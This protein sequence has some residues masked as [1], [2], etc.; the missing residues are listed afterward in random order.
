MADGALTVQLDEYTARKI[1]EKAEALG[2]SPETLAAHLLD[3]RVFDYDDFTW[4]GDDPRTA[5]VEVSDQGARD[6]EEV[7]P[8][9]LELIDK[10][11]G[12]KP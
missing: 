10:T 5:P 1:A 3:D 7:R 12:P 11:F 6:W 9:F 2:I 8:E 4:I